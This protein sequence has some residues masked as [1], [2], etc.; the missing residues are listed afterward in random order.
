MNLQELKKK[1]SLPFDLNTWKGILSELFSNVVYY[2]SEASVDANL[3]KRG[4]QIG[5][6]KLDDGHSLAVFDF[7][8]ADKIDI[9]R[10]RKGLRDIAARYV[11]QERNHGAWVFY[12]S[13]SKSDYRLTYVSKQTYFSNDGELIVNETAPKRYTFLLGPNEPCTTAAYRLNELQEHKDGSLELKHITAAFSVERLNKEFF[14]EYKQQY[15]IFLSELGED[16][17]ENRDYV[18]KLLGRLVFIQFLQKKGWMGVPITSQGWKDGDKN[19]F[20]NLVERYQGNDRLLSDV[21]EYLFFDTL[22]RRRENDLADERLG[23]GIKIPYLN[24][25]LFDK[26]SVDKLDVDFPYVLFKGLADFFS[27]YNFTIDENDPDDSEVGIDPEMLGHIFENLLEDNKD[28]GAFYT[29]KEIVQYMCEN[30][31]GQYLKTHLGDSFEPSIYKL[32]RAKFVDEIV[33]D[34]AKQIYELLCKVRV[35]DPAIGSGAFPMG[36]LNVLFQTRQLLYPYAKYKESFS[37]A[38]IKRDIIQNNIFGV[39]IEQGAV[40][41]A[42][43][44]FWLALVV[45]EEVPQPLPNLDYKIMCGNSQL[46][47]YALK[48]PISEV[49]KEYNKAGRAE[50]RRRKTE[51][52]DFTLESYKQLVTDYL[53]AHDN[54]SALREKIDEIKRCF[55]VTLANGD[56]FELQKAEAEVEDYEFVTIFGHSRKDDDPTGYEK[57]KQNL[58]KQREKVSEILN[59]QFYKDSFEWRFEYPQLLDGKGDFIGFDIII[60]NPPYLKEGRISKTFFEPYKSSPYY[61]GK[62]DIWYLF[63][64][65]GLDLLNKDGIL[66][67]IATNNWVTSF[68]A[69]KLRDKVMK[70]TRI[71][72]LV[73]FGAVMMFESA[74]IQTMI[75][76]FQKDSISDDYSF[77]YRRLNMFKA[78]EKEAIAALYNYENLLGLEIFRPIVRRSSY[79]GKNFTFSRNGAVLDAIAQ[80]P[81]VIYLRADEVAQGIV[82]PQDFLNAKNQRLLG[83][84]YIVGEGVFVLTNGDLVRLELDSTE[85]EI[86]RPY[87]T[88]EQ[89]SRYYSNKQ[90]DLWVIYTG[91]DFKSPERMRDYPRLKKHIDRFLPILTSDN[92]PYGLHRA[93][94]ERFFSRPKVVA[95]RKSVERPAFAYCDFDCY[96]SQTF[97]MI[98]TSRVDMRYL[99]G[100][101]N[102]KLAAYWFKSKGKMQGANFQLDKEPLQQIPIAIPSSSVQNLISEL[103]DYVIF[104]NIAQSSVSELVSNVVVSQFFEKVIDACVFEVYFGDHMKEKEID[105][106]DSAIALIKPISKLQLI[107]DK[108]KVIWETFMTI[109]KTDNQ[110]RDRLDLFTLRSPEILKLIIEG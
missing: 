18:K 63:A 87:Y 46:C 47:R 22:N 79:E 29:P 39:D 67:F 23:S 12:H 105:V 15:G 104:L 100:L 54:K 17:K 21:L 16:K 94:E 7:E 71:C 45:D 74:S 53:E 51:W 81:S 78:T 3:I 5:E 76:M 82:F 37:L 40:D 96:L 88:S 57:A 33:K 49:F 65:N 14:K 41:I 4:G 75:M 110:I 43:L 55:K 27:K 1:L 38:G 98:Q 9:S 26:D 31:I 73:D 60:A 32:L 85:M 64:C 13:N 108:L 8:V 61:K 19:Y 77:D 70:E 89:I 106:I 28:K 25:G 69:S 48:T 68:G 42:R 62:M 50:A 20:L 99:T 59:N 52:E 58:Q 103:V 30:S 6:I 92:R 97:N 11:D 44:R 72:N 10:N 93:R 24:G 95:I 86:M 107:N 101:L 56:I 34:N 83:D 84:G 90:N 66:C 80:N 91:S 36:I 2:T 102:S 109:K 35:C